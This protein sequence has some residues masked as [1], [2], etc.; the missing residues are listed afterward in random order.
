MQAPALTGACNRYQRNQQTETKGV[1]EHMEG[2][3][4]EL[5]GIAVILA[6]IA[7][8]SQFAFLGGAAGLAVTFG[9]CLW[10]ERNI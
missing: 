8:G 7:L 5:L 3:K 2:L 1:L 4:I 6:G 10:K 9:G